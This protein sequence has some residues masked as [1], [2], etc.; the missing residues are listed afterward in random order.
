MVLVERRAGRVLVERRAG[1][2]LVERRAGRVLVTKT[3][4]ER[5]A[6]LVFAGL[7]LSAMM[8]F[9]ALVIDI[10][11]AFQVRRQA[12]NT[13][14]AAALAGAQDLPDGAEAVASIKAYA[15]Q[16]M[17]IE[18]A[19]WIGCVDPDSL[20]YRPDLANDNQC[21]SIDEAFEKVRVR[22]PTS[23]VDTFFGGIFGVETIEVN[24]D[25][26][27][28]AQLRGDGRIIPAAV[29]AS[30]GTGYLCIENGGNNIACNAPEQGNFGSLDSPRLNL[31][32]PSANEDPN[33][34]RTNYAM[35]LDH[36]V[37]LYSSGATIVCDGVNRSNCDTTNELS[38]ATAN[39]LNLYTGNVPPPITDGLVAGFTINTDDQGNNITFCG[40]L[41]RPDVTDT[42]LTETAPGGCSSPGAPT[43]TVMSGN[44]AKV[45]NGR[46]VSYWMASWARAV[47]YPEIGN[48]NY[49]TQG[50]EGLYAAGDARLACFLNG[51]RYDQSTGVETIPTCSGVTLPNG[52]D[53]VTGTVYPMFDLGTPNDP[54]FG[55]IPEIEDF[56]SGQSK[57]VKLTNFWAMFSYRLYY[58]DTK[59]LG[60]DAWVF[61]PA[62]IETESGEPGLQFGFQPDPVVHLIE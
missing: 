54:R 3:A 39:Y 35:S 56:A 6:V 29:S 14:D 40:R 61:D 2:V 12:Q 59:I 20:A 31:Y 37:K 28:E 30:A 27:A 42:N 49:P 60:Y 9:A 8:G 23:Q 5:G 10:A 36:A 22:L 55:V 13:A 52:H 50:Y 62:L 15:E 38:S 48:M 26:V 25:A 45:I 33:S 18:A 4:R 19:D 11:N 51:Y 53:G 1:R 43:I 58:S 32:Q 16:N 41:A 17:G 44:N 24:A 47:F 7:T 57:A 34:L 21:I 46:H